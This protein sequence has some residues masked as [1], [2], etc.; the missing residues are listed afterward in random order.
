MLRSSSRLRKTADLLRPAIVLGS[1]VLVLGGCAAGTAYTP[2]EL[3]ARCER[4][5]GWWHTGDNGGF[6][7]IEGAGM[8]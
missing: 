7:E 8:V 4:D 5:G 2:E 6:C 3:K 1:L